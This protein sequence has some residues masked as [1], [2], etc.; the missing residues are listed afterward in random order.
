MLEKEA[1]GAAGDKGKGDGRLRIGLMVREPRNAA[2]A[3][4]GR[5]TACEA[6][7]QNDNEKCVMC[8]EKSRRLVDFEQYL[9]QQGYCRR[10]Y[11]LTT[12]G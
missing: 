9:D 1:A 7:F 12:S 3:G 2:R 8:G 4:D 10:C 5:R 11:G 6:I